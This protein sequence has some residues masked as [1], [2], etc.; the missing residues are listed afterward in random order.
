MG[1]DTSERLWRA[2]EL[3]AKNCRRGI[4]TKPL[5]FTVTRRTGSTLYYK[6]AVSSPCLASSALTI[7]NRP[8]PRSIMPLRENDG[9]LAWARR[10][11]LFHV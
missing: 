10:L 1:E 2:R 11:S 8:V 9:L 3:D 7:P 5:A 6:I 4:G